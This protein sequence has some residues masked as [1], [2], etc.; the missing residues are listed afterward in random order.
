[1]NS[2]IAKI[3]TTLAVVACLGGGAYFL[4][5]HTELIKSVAV[6]PKPVA[7]NSI[8]AE[9]KPNHGSFRE[10]FQPALPTPSPQ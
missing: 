6:E 7:Q 10:R 4:I 2:L 3:V 5:Y 9:P 1:M 8:P